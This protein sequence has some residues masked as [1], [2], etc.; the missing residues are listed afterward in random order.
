MKSVIRNHIKEFVLKPSSLLVLCFLALVG[1]HMYM[2]RA[3]TLPIIL[4]DEFGYLANAAFFAGLNWSAVVKSIPFYSFGYSLFLVPLFWVSVNPF[5]IYAGALFVNAVLASA[6]IFPA[7]Y[8]GKELVP[9]ADEGVVLLA[10]LAVTL[11]PTNIVYSDLAWSECCLT[12]FYWMSVFVFLRLCS[13]RTAYRNIVLF[14]LLIVFLNVIHPRAIGILVAGAVSLILL[15]L[16]GKISLRHVAVS[17][18]VLLP[19]YSAFRLTKS[20]LIQNLWLHGNRSS[21]NTLSRAPLY[22]N[23]LAKLGGFLNSI[24][25]AVAR[26]FYLSSASYLVFQIGFFFILIYVTKY[27]SSKYAKKYNPAH[28]GWPDEALSL[29]MMYMLLSFMAV[30]SVTAIVASKGASRADYIFYGRYHEAFIGPILLIGLLYAGNQLKLLN[31]NI[32]SGTFVFNAIFFG[33]ISTLAYLFFY[34]V[35][36]TY[37][38]YFVSITGFFPYRNGSWHIDLFRILINVIPTMVVL[39]FAVR[40]KPRFGFL[41]VC[42]MFVWVARINVSDYLALAAKSKTQTVS[43][44]DSHAGILKN[45]PVYV[46]PWGPHMGRRTEL[47]QLCLPHNR[48][49]PVKDTRKLKLI[50]TKDNMVVV[51]ADPHLDNKL[52]WLILAGIDNDRAAYWWVPRRLASK[53][54]LNDAAVAD[55]VRETHESKMK[56]KNHPAENIYLSSIRLLSS[57]SVSLSLLKGEFIDILSDIKL[58]SPFINSLEYNSRVVITNKSA[59]VWPPSVTVGVFWSPRQRRGG[60]IGEYRV[61]LPRLA[62]GESIRLDIPIKLIKGLS[63]GQYVVT[64]DLIQE[65]VAWFYQKGQKPVKLLVALN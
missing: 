6:I 7:Y 29:G 41:L 57:N 26:F 65:H 3:M 27:F 18:A 59:A 37:K 34:K 25:M 31:R 46:I 42:L 35:I 60:R 23:R 12:F 16:Y 55:S 61:D 63:R 10:A 53:F 38:T 51:A 11:Y 9:Y 54:H 24:E 30:F 5:F 21:I 50:K 45:Y 1:F 49:T 43:F 44:A 14:C 52:P 15:F 8:I 56:K 19:A 40:F 36:G 2:A 20:Y 58:L 48:F 39:L 13:G 47:Y 64:I 33:F 22:L 28:S 4:D 17:V 62:P 32:S